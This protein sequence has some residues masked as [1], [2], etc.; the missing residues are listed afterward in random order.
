MTVVTAARVVPSRLMMPLLILGAGVFA[1]LQSLVTPALP[2]IQRE[3]GTT[4][5]AAIGNPLQG[6]PPPGDGYTLGFG[7]LAVLCVAAAASATL[8]PRP[9]PRRT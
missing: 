1:L 5:S 8:I 4:A 6:G 2:Q 7:V 9:S 3:L